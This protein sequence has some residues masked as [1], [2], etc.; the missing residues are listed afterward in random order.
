MTVSNILKYNLNLPDVSTPGLI[1]MIT[2]TAI[3]LGVGLYVRYRHRK[4][5]GYKKKEPIDVYRK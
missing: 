5:E 3:L 1:G 4:R 2:V